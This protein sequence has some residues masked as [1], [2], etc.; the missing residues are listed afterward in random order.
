MDKI[1]TF[2]MS[3]AATFR[4]NLYPTWTYTPLTLIISI[5]NQVK[6]VEYIIEM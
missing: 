2:P 1:L 3:H 5:E 4:N 6:R